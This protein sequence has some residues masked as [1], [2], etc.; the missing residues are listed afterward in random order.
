MDGNGI[1]MSEF[2]ELMQTKERDRHDPRRLQEVPSCHWTTVMVLWGLNEMLWTRHSKCV[3]RGADF[4]LGRFFQKN[5]H[6]NFYESERNWLAKDMS[7]TSEGWPSAAAR[8]TSRPF[9][10]R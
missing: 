7:I 8:F 5:P 1:G 9:A 4:L 6:P 2:V 3:G 10:S